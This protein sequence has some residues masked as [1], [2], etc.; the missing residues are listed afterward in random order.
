MKAR[1]KLASRATKEACFP[2]DERDKMDNQSKCMKEHVLVHMTKASLF[3]IDRSI[4]ACFG[5][6][7]VDGLGKVSSNPRQQRQ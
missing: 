6:E 2:N 3:I 4:L 7:L 1:Y 5:C